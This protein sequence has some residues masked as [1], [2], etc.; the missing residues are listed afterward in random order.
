SWNEAI[1]AIKDGRIDMV[2]GLKNTEARREF[3]LFSSDY[4]TFPLV[5]MTRDTHPVIAS[6]AGIRDGNLA[7]AENYASTQEIRARYPKLKVHKVG[8]LLEAMRAVE[9][10]DADATVIN[11]GSAS[12]LIARYR[13][14]GV[15][16]A[17]P[18]GLEDARSAFG[19]RRD[20]LE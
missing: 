13:I 2:A 19:V 6:L 11:L 17:A 8:N 7:L 1:D 14:K 15:V 10:G 16:V 4:L 20:W 9:R 5:I 18:A 3:L 12:Y